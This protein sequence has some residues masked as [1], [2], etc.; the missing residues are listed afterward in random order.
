[1]FDGMTTLEIV[2]LLAPY[3]ILELCFKVFSLYRLVK[4]QV[5]YLPKWCWIL[6]ILFVNTFGPISYLLIGRVKD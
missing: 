3:I 2:K 4:D 6:I 5:K 1:M